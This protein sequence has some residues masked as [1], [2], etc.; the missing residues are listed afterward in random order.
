[1]KRIVLMAA[2]A[3]TGCG[4]YADFRLPPIAGPAHAVRFNF[5]ARPSPVLSRGAPGAFDSHDVLNPAVVARDGLQYNF[6]SGF[7]GATW[8]TGL[9]TSRDGIEW[10]K[11]GVVLA[12]DAG[13]WEAN[14]IA[15]NGSA[16]L[17]DGRFWYWYVGGSKEL[18]KLGLA[19]SHDGRTFTK[20]RDPVLD[21]GPRGSWDERGVADP[22]VIRSGA[23]FYLF[24]LGQDRARRQRLGVARSTDGVHFEKLRTNP[25]LELGEDG[26]FDEQGLGEPAVWHSLG[27]YWMLY[28]G[29]DRDERRRMGLAQ[30]RDGV[31]WRRL[32]GVFAGQ[33]PWN[34]EVICD[35]EVDHGASAVKIW[36]GGG[37]IRKPDENLNGQIGAGTLIAVS[38]ATLKQ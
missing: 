2:V 21:T 9:A 20:E 25:V 11:Q 38:D 33:E 7:D 17:V 23:Y 27:W 8:R 30:S 3:L 13:T 24:Y 32:P 29:R 14:Y 36:F 5:N 4:R 18:P 1:V 10:Q 6:Y 28:T 16:L 34:S 19:R 35:A 12:P 31:V 26:N 22:Y 15:A 37:N